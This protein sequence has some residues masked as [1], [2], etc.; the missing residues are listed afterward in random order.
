MNITINEQNGA[1]VAVIEGRLDSV[2]APEFETKIQ[3]LLEHANGHIVLECKDMDY[4]SSAGL[5]QF[6]AVRKTAL[7]KGGSVTVANIQEDV[8][9]VFS[10]TGFLDLF[11]FQG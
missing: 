6:L 9:Q 8:R 4:I 5:R 1:W 7:A 11:D 10:L 3:P 2:T